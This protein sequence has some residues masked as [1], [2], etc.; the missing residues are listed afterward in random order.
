VGDPGGV[1]ER[2]RAYL[3]DHNLPITAQR[4]AIADAVLG[5]D[6]HLSVE[7]L[8]VELSARGAAAGTATIYRTL[9]LLQTSGLVAERDFGEGFKR[10][11]PTR[12]VPHHEHLLC[13]VCGRV[14]EFRDERLERMTTL[15]A[16][17]HSYLRQRHRLVIYG[18]CGRCAGTEQR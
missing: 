7:E 14:T 10:Y 18:V 13:T 12:D 6:R 11:E 2:F 16:E 17:G 8:A 9:E 4:L 1:I 5:S 15:I 3:R